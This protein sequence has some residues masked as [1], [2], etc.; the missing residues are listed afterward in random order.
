M[1]IPFK[2]VS[3]STLA[4]F[5]VYTIVIWISQKLILPEEKEK[6]VLSIL[7]LTVVISIVHFV[8][9]LLIPE[10]WIWLVIFAIAGIGLIKKWFDVDW[11]R[12]IAIGAISAVLA[13]L[14]A[15]LPQIMEMLGS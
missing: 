4:N 11:P 14:L 15:Y 5:I 9:R 1:E 3:Q 12:G 7:V 2:E 8:L 13:Q 6:G 10:F